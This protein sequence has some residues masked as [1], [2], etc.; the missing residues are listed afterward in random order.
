LSSCLRVQDTARDLDVVIDSQLSL[1]AHVAAVC[2]SGYQ[3]RQLRQAARSLS[4]DAMKTLIQA[5]ISCRLDYCNALFFGISEALNA[6]DE[7]VAVRSER[8]RSASYWYTIG[9]A[10]TYRRCSVYFLLPVRQRVDCK[11][12]TLVHRSLS[13][14]LPSSLADD[15]RLIADARERRLRSTEKR[16]CVL[17]RTT[18]ALVTE[19]LQL[20]APDY[21]TVY[22]YISEMFQRSLYKKHFC[23][24]VGPRRSVNH[25]NR[26]A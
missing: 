3:L 20:P 5:F 12:G 17:T 25:F 4:E 23:W 6:T 19:L 16:T 26:V 13:E 10:T 22:H 15:C 9:V 18:A 24:I 21:G 1:S 7:P 2:R 11:V 14:N 8:C